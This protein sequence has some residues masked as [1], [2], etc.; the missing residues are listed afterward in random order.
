MATGFGRTGKM[1]ACEHERV[2]PDILALAKGITGGYM[3]LAAT[4]TT[5]KV[6]RAFLGR[7]QDQKT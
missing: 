7:H 6:F 4:L 5:E 3:P 2:T 1:F